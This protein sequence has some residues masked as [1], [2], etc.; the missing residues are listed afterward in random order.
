MDPSNNHGQPE[1]ESFAKESQEAFASLKQEFKKPLRRIKRRVLLEF[2]RPESFAKTDLI[3][4]V[5]KKLHLRNY[6]EL[7]TPISGG[8]YWDIH[9]W[10]FDA[11]RRLMYNCDCP[12]NYYNDG[13]PI[14]FRIANFDIGPAVDKLKMDVNKIDICLVDGWH[15]YDCSI[16]DLRCFYE[17]LADGG[18]LIVHDV[19]PHSELVASPTFVKDDWSGVTYKAFI[20]FVLTQHDLDYC[21]VDADYGC[22]II[23]K[24]RTMNFM[25][26]VSSVRKSTLASDWFSIH[27]DDKTAFMFFLE[28]HKQLLRLISAKA[29][30]H[31]LSPGYCN[32]PI[33][34]L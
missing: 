8:K 10:R 6:L 19:L 32:R 22:G 7:C 5:S 20:D 24:N 29:F 34:T 15:T 33:T 31:G 11:V 27:D 18:V 30:I 28:N 26:D 4:F 1:S 14:D 2:G 23:I 3:H 25:G 9:R 13:L 12:Y 21:A 16:R 17:L